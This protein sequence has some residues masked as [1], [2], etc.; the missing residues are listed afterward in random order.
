MSRAKVIHKWY[1]MCAG[2]LRGVMLHVGQCDDVGGGVCDVSGELL[3][4][5]VQR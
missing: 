1:G 5:S 4:S 2:R 3:A